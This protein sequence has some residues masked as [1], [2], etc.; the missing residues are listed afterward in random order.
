MKT[1]GG[2]VAPRVSGPAVRWN[3]C[4]AA[5]LAATRCSG[6]VTG[7]LLPVVLT[8]RLMTERQTTSHLP[9]RTKLP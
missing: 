2:K 4:G 3:E 9:D 8:S 5:K 7:K 1:Q 6:L